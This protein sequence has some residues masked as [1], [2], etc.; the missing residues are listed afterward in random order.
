MRFADLQ[1]LLDLYRRRLVLPAERSG[2][3]ADL[4]EPEIRDEGGWLTVGAP[5]RPSCTV[6]WRS[7]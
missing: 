2:E 5:E 1:E 7:G 6:W 3:L 4:L